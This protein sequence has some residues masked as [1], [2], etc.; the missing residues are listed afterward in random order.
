MAD[1]T[2]PPRTPVRGGTASSIASGA[3]GAEI[4]AVSLGVF[5]I[6]VLVTVVFAALRRHQRMRWS[7][8]IIQAGAVFAGTV[9]FTLTV[10]G[11]V[12]GRWP[13]G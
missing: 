4:A 12:M 7:D 5:V 3:N 10:L 8:V 1:A 9:V 11:A 6:A 13:V 2:V